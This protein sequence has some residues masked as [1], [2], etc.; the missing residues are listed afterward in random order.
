[1]NMDEIEFFFFWFGT[2]M[3]HSMINPNH[4]RMEGIPVSD[5]LFDENQNIG[6]DREKAFIPFSNV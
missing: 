6:I 1:M 3:D 4:I 5:D 2:C